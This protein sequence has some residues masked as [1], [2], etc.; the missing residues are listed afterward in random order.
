MCQSLGVESIGNHEN[1]DDGHGHLFKLESVF[2]DVYSIHSFER[3]LDKKAKI[4]NIL[5]YKIY[6]YTYLS[7][8]LIRLPPYS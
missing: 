3:Q 4:E 7:L 8:M 1:D 5:T 2:S 6:S